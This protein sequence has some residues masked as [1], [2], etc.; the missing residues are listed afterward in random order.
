[1]SCDVNPTVRNLFAETKVSSAKVKAGNLKSVNSV[2]HGMPLQQLKPAT[3]SVCSDRTRPSPTPAPRTGTLPLLS[4]FS[5][6]KPHCALEK[7]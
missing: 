5:E 4:L 6:Q 3:D 7:S 2:V 1:M